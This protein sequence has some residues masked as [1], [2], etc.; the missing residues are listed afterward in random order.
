MN[1]QDTITTL[2]NDGN[3]SLLFLSTR[4]SPSDESV[5]EDQKQSQ[6]PGAT[7]VELD[8]MES[9]VI[10]P[11]PIQNDTVRKSGSLSDSHSL[12]CVPCN[13]KFSRKDNYRQHRRTVHKKPL[14][15]CTEINLPAVVLPDEKDPNFYCRACNKTY[16]RWYTYRSH[17]QKT[18]EMALVPVPSPSK[19]FLLPNQKYD[20]RFSRCQTCGRYFSSKC[21]YIQHL[22]KAHQITLPVPNPH[23]TPDENDPDLYCKAC[24]IHSIS[25]S[26]FDYHLRRTHK[27]ILTRRIYT[28]HDR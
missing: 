27:M 4:S 24:K 10:T 7:L 2:E 26:A 9:P 25:R 1:S 15:S 13:R 17:L 3:Y 16:S 5:D 28:Y 23:L 22:R 20:D 8:E 11:I 14:K 6:P 18:H 21:G 19:I 12:Y